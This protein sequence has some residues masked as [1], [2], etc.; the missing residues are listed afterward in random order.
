M[1]KIDIAG[2]PV[3]NQNKQVSI[4]EIRNGLGLV[5]V[6]GGLT[7]SCVLIKYVSTNQQESKVGLKG[8]GGMVATLLCKSYSKSYSA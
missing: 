3:K 7:S 5:F 8:F 4:V 1:D 2:E 6:W